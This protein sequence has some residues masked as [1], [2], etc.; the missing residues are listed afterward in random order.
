[1]TSSKL[2]IVVLV[3]VL[4]TQIRQG[5]RVR[6]LQISEMPVQYLTILRREVHVTE[7]PFFS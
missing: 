6:E 7:I 4:Q 2:E 1:M 5:C 3:P